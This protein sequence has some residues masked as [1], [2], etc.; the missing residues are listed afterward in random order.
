MNP[1]QSPNTGVG[2]SAHGNREQ[3]NKWEHDIKLNPP[4]AGG[5]V[6]LLCDWYGGEFVMLGTRADYKPGSSTKQKKFGFRF[7]Q[8]GEKINEIPSAWRH[9]KA[10]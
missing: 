7:M 2:G 5:E 4:P 9:K 10:R 3:S 1:M 8:N 6:E